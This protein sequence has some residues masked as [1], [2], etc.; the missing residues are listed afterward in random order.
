MRKTGKLG[1]HYVKVS[2]A[3]AALGDGQG[4]EPRP[5]EPWRGANQLMLVQ[6]AFVEALLALI[7]H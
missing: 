2:G 6:F 5:L 1:H 4:L 7:G 3:G